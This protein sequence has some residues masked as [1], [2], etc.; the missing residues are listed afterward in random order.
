M[1]NC[2]ELQVIESDEQPLFCI[3]HCSKHDS[4]QDGFGVSI[5]PSNIIQAE[6]RV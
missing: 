4:Y 1:C 3:Y 5:E 2:L 6:V